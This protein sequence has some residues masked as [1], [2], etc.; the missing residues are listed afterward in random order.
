VSDV[1]SVGDLVTPAAM[2]RRASWMS[3]F[4]VNDPPAPHP[5]PVVGAE[6]FDPTLYPAPDAAMSLAGWAQ[7]NDWCVTM[8]YAR[9]TSIDARGRP[10]RVV[11]SLAVRMWRFPDQRAVATY[12]DG[13]AD[14]GWMWLVGQIPRD[15]GVAA[16]KLALDGTE[17]I[18][19]PKLESVKGA[20]EACGNLVVI[21]KDGTL[22]VHGPRDARC[23]GRKPLA[24][25][26]SS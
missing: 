10:N 22:R 17:P 11:D 12:M 23:A 1:V 2:A 18:A 16:L 26:P 21:N 7:L 5:A 15:V 24:V 14:G 13:R 9:G 3:R 8:T 6:P 20:C 4:D 25:A 19:R